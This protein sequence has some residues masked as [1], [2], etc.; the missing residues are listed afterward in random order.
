MVVAVDLV[1]PGRDVV[2]VVVAAV[3]FAEEAQIDTFGARHSSE[4][5]CAPLLSCSSLALFNSSSLTP[6]PFPLLFS[7]ALRRAACS[8]SARRASAIRWLKV[9]AGA[10]EGDGVIGLETNGSDMLVCGRH[11]DVEV[12]VDAT[13]AIGGYR[14]FGARLSETSFAR[15]PRSR[16][17]RTREGD[18]GGCF[19]GEAV[20]WTLG[21]G[22]EVRGKRG[23]GVGAGAGTVVW[24]L[25][26][27]SKDV[28]AVFKSNLGIDCVCVCC[29]VVVVVVL[30]DPS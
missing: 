25:R 26:A 2:V 7:I 21:G 20:T 3:R 23:R 24:S 6:H 9:F 8:V 19:A 30:P 29:A 16:P 10:A 14:R 28:D 18:G 13:P 12:E 15:R 1:V 4:L 22:V 11:V 5:S 17:R 27:W